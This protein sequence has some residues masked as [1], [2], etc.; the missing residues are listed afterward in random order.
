MKMLKEITLDCTNLG[1]GTLTFVAHSFR[2]SDV[3]VVDLTGSQLLT[4][5]HRII[6]IFNENDIGFMLKEED[7]KSFRTHIERSIRNT[8]EY[9]TDFRTGRERD[10]W[11]ESYEKDN[12]TVRYQRSL[13]VKNIGD[14]LLQKIISIYS[15]TPVINELQLR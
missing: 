4:F 15:T 5:N 6:G 9:K 7:L 11:L 12:R 1:Y 8:I 14:L 3:K 13:V 2:I 10:D